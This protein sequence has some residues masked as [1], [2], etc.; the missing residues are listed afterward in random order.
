MTCAIATSLLIRPFT[1]Q[2]ADA[3]LLIRKRNLEKEDS[4]DYPK[5]KIQKIT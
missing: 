2:D 5:K 4:V 1:P 3:V